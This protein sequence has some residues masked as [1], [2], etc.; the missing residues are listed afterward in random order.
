[1]SFITNRQ[2]IIERFRHN[3][4]AIRALAIGITDAQAR[5]KPDGESWSILE[6]INHLYD[7]ERRDFR[8]RLD[9]TLHRPEQEWPPIDPGA[10][11]LDEHYNERD[12]AVS[13]ANFLTEREKSL[14]W[15][16]QLDDPDWDSTRKHPAG[17]TM[18]AGDL[19]ASWLAH[20]ALHLRQL[21]ELHHQYVAFSLNPYNTAYAGDF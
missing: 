17:F 3:A 12:L 1:M 2:Q 13:L 5:W 9:L 15:I 10:W 4:G 7:E 14:D 20:D 21:A 19:L 16:S 6:V 8:L 11:V 18:K